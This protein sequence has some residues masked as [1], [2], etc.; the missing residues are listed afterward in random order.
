MMKNQNR[1]KFAQLPEQQQ[2]VVAGVVLS[3]AAIVLSVEILIIYMLIENIENKAMGV[4]IVIGILAMTLMIA[5]NIHKL[6]GQ[7]TVLRGGRIT[8][9]VQYG[10]DVLRRER[11]N[12]G[13]DPA[14]SLSA[15]PS[16]AILFAIK[17]VFFAVISFI[18]MIFALII[19]GWSSF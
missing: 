6:S 1:K 9:V 4:L 7:K 17:G 5:N 19:I 14:H 12:G 16:R 8:K 15:Q 2:K 3:I 18:A 13:K 10:Q 11:G